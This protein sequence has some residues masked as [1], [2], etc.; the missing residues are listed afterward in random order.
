MHEMAESSNP[1]WCIMSLPDVRNSAAWCSLHVAFSAFCTITSDRDPRP[2]TEVLN[3]SASD[4]NAAMKSMWSA[5]S[6]SRNAHISAQTANSTRACLL[7]QLPIELLE[8]ILRY[9]IVQRDSPTTLFS[10]RRKG[11]PGRMTTKQ[12]SHHVFRGPTHPPLARTCRLLRRESLAILY[13]ERRVFV[14]L[15]SA[16]TKRNSDDTPVWSAAQP[17]IEG[18][19]GWWLKFPPFQ[20]AMPYLRDIT[21]WTNCAEWDPFQR[22]WKREVGSV[23][24]KMTR[25]SYGSPLILEC[26][27]HVSECC[28][29]RL[30][31]KVDALNSAYMGEMPVPGNHII[32]E[33]L[34]WLVTNNVL[35]NLGYPGESE[36][37]CER[38]G[39]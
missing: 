7:L 32:L 16:D 33:A 19:L 17:V 39:K 37:P 5:L 20:T 27:G 22:D 28:Y 4:M 36:D 6:I 9:A 38:C 34:E 30:I 31:D 12:K 23:R 8:E 11:T 35:E 29:C 24:L 18:T 14:D 13:R 25:S 3:R 15:T 26:D 2:P 10:I 21:L 1:Q